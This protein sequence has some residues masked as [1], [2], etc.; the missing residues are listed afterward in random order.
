MRNIA[1]VES[2]GEVSANSGSLECQLAISSEPFSSL[3]FLCT[4]SFA[5]CR[6]FARDPKEID[7]I[8]RLIIPRLAAEKLNKKPSEIQLFQ[9]ETIP[10]RLEAG[11]FQQF[12]VFRRHFSTFS[13]LRRRFIIKTTVGGGRAASKHNFQLLGGDNFF[14]AHSQSEKVFQPFWGR[15]CNHYRT[16]NFPYLGTIKLH[17]CGAACRLM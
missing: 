13:A 16:C 4:T 9:I 10:Y 11:V 5:T 17:P 1:V 3:A 6:G 7:I 15:I 12:F 8:V 14:L 2:V